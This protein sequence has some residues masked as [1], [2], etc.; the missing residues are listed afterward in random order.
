MRTGYW[1]Q[2]GQID[3][4]Y[5]RFVDKWNLKKLPCSSST[6]SNDMKALMSKQH[7]HCWC[8][9][10]PLGDE[11]VMVQCSLYIFILASLCSFFLLSPPFSLLVTVF[12]PFAF[13]FPVLFFLM[14]AWMK[15]KPQADK[16]VRPWNCL[17]EAENCK[18]AIIAYPWIF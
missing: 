6:L 2:G 15:S 11:G 8:T 3:W 14:G 18:A 7:A 5:F 13:S 10:S 1:G 16:I 9:A 4:F 17:A 12:F